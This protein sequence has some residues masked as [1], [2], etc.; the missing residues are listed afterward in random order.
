MLAKMLQY[1]ITRLLVE[2]S[3]S[4]ELCCILGSKQEANRPTHGLKDTVKKPAGNIYMMLNSSHS[5]NTSRMAFKNTTWWPNIRTT[6]TFSTKRSTSS[7]QKWPKIILEKLWRKIWFDTLI[8][9]TRSRK[10]LGK[11]TYLTTKYH[12]SFCSKHSTSWCFTSRE[13]WPNMKDLANYKI[14]DIHGLKLEY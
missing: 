4:I 9:T 13:T 1:A 12:W 6:R 5:N 14:G 10:W 8:Y 7:S 3:I 2:V 11:A